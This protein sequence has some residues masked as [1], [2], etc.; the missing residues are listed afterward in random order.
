MGAA[1]MKVT[2]DIRYVGVNDHDIDLFES[3]YKVP[4]GMA[5]NSYVIAD[6]KI[7][8]MD[9]AAREFGGEWMKNIKQATGGRK[10]DYLIIQHMEPDHSY[11]I[12]T[13][14]EKYPEAVVVGNTK[15]FNMISQFYGI[16]DENK[17]VVKNDDTLDLGRHKLSFLFAPMVHWPEVMMTYDATD[18]VLFTADAFGKFGAN[19]TEDPNGWE[20][21]ARRY[22]I[23]IVGKYGMQVQNILKKTADLGFR[24]ICPLHGPV[25]KGDLTHY[26]NLYNTWSS[27]QPEEEG[28]TIAYSSVYG[29][30]RAAVEKLAGM[31]KKKNCPAVAI[32][33][34]S[35][36]DLHEAVASAF[37]YSKLVL[38]TTTYNADIFPTMRTYIEN[39]T[40]RNF[41][42]RTVGMI[43]NGSW[44]PMAAKVMRGLLEKSKNLTMTETTVTLKSALN[45]DSEAQLQKLAD[46]LA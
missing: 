42:N 21:E 10:P 25:L 9:T 39:L 16:C 40:E 30:T 14:I 36:D 5:Y 3:Q 46:E 29:D 33:D 44:A 18:K 17:L 38:A 8:V 15:T 11:N 31:L 32:Y 37:R 7:A 27:Y 2:D 28:V 34:V 13:F 22:Y 6:D 45:E 4:R 41:Q 23:G 26:L 24:T 12:R 43:E 35:R 20:A 1:D 19:D